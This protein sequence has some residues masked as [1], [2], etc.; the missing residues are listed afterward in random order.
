MVV[1]EN[2]T[3]I[4]SNASCSLAGN[5]NLTEADM[6]CTSETVTGLFLLIT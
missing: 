2:G 5:A 1:A 6:D 3:Q 4:A